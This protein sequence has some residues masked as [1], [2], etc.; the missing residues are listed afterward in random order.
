LALER[1]EKC[2][3]TRTNVL[4]WKTIAERETRLM[5][6]ADKGKAIENAISHIEKQFGKGAIMKLGEASQRMAV[7][8]IS[9]GSISLDIA[10]GG[11]DGA[12]R[13]ARVRDGRHPRRPAGAAD[14]AGAAQAD[15]CHQPQPHVP[16]LHQSAAR[17]GRRDVR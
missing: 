16:D 3:N 7:D 11:R 13:R 4:S 17:E 15:G 14:V 10:L 12:A 5:A 1:L 2:W 8:A 6:D 9:T